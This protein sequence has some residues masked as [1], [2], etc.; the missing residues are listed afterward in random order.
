MADPT[1]DD[2]PARKRPLRETLLPWITTPLL[3]ALLIAV[4]HVY[5]A[6]THLSAFILPA[7]AKVW[8]WASR[9]RS[10]S[11]SRLASCS[12]ACVGSN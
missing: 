3:L 4:W 5:V 2:T 7:P 8:E 10:P 9:G 11:E 6:T 12:G 1:P